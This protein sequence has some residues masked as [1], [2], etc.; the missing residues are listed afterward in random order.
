[1]DRK[2]SLKTALRIINRIRTQGLNLEPIETLPKGIKES[3]RSCPIANALD[4]RAQVDGDYLI[5][6]NKLDAKKVAR[7][8]RKGKDDNE[9]VI[10]ATLGNFVTEF[11]DGAYPHLIRR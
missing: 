6:R 4:K 2:P 5:F 10:P 7:L 8:I 1:M 3:L 11:D 9:V